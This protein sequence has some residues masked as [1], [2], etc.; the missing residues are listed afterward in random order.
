MKKSAN[1]EGDCN[2]PLPERVWKEG[3][4]LHFG[5]WATID[6]AQNNIQKMDAEVENLKAL[7]DAIKPDETSYAVGMFFG[8]MF[9]AGLLILILRLVY[10]LIKY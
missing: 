2:A 1:E 5:V 4:T 6:D 10:Q 8:Y 7:R 3:Q 9:L